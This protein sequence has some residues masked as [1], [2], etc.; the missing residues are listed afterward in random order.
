MI[1]AITGATISGTSRIVC[2]SFWPG[3]AVEQQ[4]QRKARDQRAEHA[5]DHEEEGVGQ[6]D[7]EERRIVITESIVAKPTQIFLGL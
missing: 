7:V 6:H 5:Q 3:R 1:A 4:R 2:T